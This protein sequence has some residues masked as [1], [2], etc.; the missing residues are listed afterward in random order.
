MHLVY[1]RFWFS[2]TIWRLKASLQHPLQSVK[3]FRNSVDVKPSLLASVDLL[4]LVCWHCFTSSI[5]QA[6]AHPCTNL[7]CFLNL[8]AKFLLLS[9]SQRMSSAADLSITA[10]ARVGV[11]GTDGCIQPSIDASPEHWYQVCLLRLTKHDGLPIMKIWP[12]MCHK[13]FLY[14]TD[15][16]LSELS[17]KSTLEALQNTQKPL[18]Y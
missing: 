13:V 14:M 11:C 17:S 6:M 2:H 10:S 16:A 18:A 7:H 8:S 3:I 5:Q 1:L 15:K 9:A 12:L 4:F